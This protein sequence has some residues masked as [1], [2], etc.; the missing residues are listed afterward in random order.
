MPAVVGVHIQIRSSAFWSALSSSGREIVHPPPHPV[1]IR[2]HAVPEFLLKHVP[3]LTDG[4]VDMEVMGWRG[5]TSS[6]P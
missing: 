5:L 2:R 1:Y 6:C 3:E 4:I